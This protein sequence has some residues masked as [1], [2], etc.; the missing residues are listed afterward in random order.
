MLNSVYLPC[1]F[2]AQKEA[3]MPG[4]KMVRGWAIA[5]NVVMAGVQVYLAT[6]SD[7]P[8]LNVLTALGTAATACL[9]YWLD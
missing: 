5:L 8:V 4:R 9:L 3:R 2:S 1:R 6:S 7:K